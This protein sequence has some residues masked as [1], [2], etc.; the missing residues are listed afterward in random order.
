MPGMCG[1]IRFEKETSFKYNSVACRQIVVHEGFTDCSHL[2]L[3]FIFK[4]P[5]PYVV[6]PTPV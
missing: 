2:S 1:L 6:L 5:R 3:M 4:A